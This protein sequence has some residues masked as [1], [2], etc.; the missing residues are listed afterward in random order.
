VT[1]TAV[2]AEV[3][4]A[5]IQALVWIALALYV[6]FWPQDPP[7]LQWHVIETFAALITVGVLA[8]AYTAGVIIDRVA[9]TVVT[10][11]DT[12]RLSLGTS[13]R[14][15]WCQLR[16]KTTVNARSKVG[17]KDPSFGE[18]RLHVRFKGGSMSSFLDY[19]R[20]RVRV[21]R[22]TALNILLAT[23]FCYS[24]LT[25]STQRH[26]V[27]GVGLIAFLLSFYAWVR[28]KSVYEKRLRQAYDLVCK[29]EG[30]ANAPPADGTG[31]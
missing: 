31:V 24:A 4:T 7:E 23:I 20:S 2:F 18:M 15:A 8:L 21:A 16:G 3:L 13:A 14:K 30:A 28:I 27:A 29:G 12:L 11:L 6:F 10:K 26:S 22:S 17:Q 19:A 1:T 25:N 9:D 5:G